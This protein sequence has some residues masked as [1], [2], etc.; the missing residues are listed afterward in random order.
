MRLAFLSDLNDFV[1]LLKL[2]QNKVLI[3]LSEHVK[4][5]SGRTQELLSTGQIHKPSAPNIHQF[6][7]T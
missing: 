1:S 2:R 4:A 5:M 7:T 6:W 3:S